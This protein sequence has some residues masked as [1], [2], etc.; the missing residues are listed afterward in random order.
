MLTTLLS[1]A[2]PGV[3]AQFTGNNPN[4]SLASLL[5]SGQAQ[6]TPEQA[7]QVDPSEVQALAQ[8]VEQHN[9]SIIDRVSEV[10]SEHPTLIKTLGAV[11]LGIAVKK[12]AENHQI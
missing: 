7:A 9:P 3:L 11:A 2:G 12:I 6:V 10:Y 1:T 8:H 4:S 5:Q